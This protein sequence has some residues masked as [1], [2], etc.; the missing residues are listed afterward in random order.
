MQKPRAKIG[1]YKTVFKGHTF[2]VKRAIAVMP[3]GKKEV[4]ETMH[5]PPS[6]MI[7]PID[8]KKRLL[9]IREYRS[10]IKKYIW[11]LPA[12]KV[13]KGETPVRAAQRELRE[14]AGVRA[15]NLKLFRLAEGGQSWV[16]RRFA[17]VAT[18]LTPDRLLKDEDEDIKVVP[19]SIDKAFQM[20]KKD[21]IYNENMACMI[22]RLWSLRKKFGI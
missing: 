13:K 2:E 7:L 20:I 14:E 15:K 5:R 17:Y 9:L 1:K 8:A 11:A 3:S 10:R 4:F 6:V 18:K 19:V 22:F 16:W 12:G 21:L